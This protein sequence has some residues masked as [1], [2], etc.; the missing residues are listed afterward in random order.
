MQEMLRL[1]IEAGGEAQDGRSLEYAQDVR[2]CFNLKERKQQKQINLL[3][4]REL[5]V[6]KLIGEGA[7]NEEIAKKL[8]ISVSTVKSHILNL[9]G[10]LQ[11]KS[12]SKAIV[13][14][15]KRGMF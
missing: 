3:T 2:S 7:S 15:K 4:K 12:R 11:V 10:K 14:A 1:F 8:F 5:E 6:I 13:E 9:F